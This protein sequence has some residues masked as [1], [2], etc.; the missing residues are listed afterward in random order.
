[1]FTK[2]Q[3]YICSILVYY[4]V[5]ILQ[6]SLYCTFNKYSQYYQQFEPFPQPENPCNTRKFMGIL[7]GSLVLEGHHAVW[8]VRVPCVFFLFTRLSKFNLEFNRRHILRVL[9]NNNLSVNSCMY[10]LESQAPPVLEL[11]VLEKS[12]RCN[13]AVAALRAVSRW[14]AVV[15]G[16][17][18]RSNVL[19]MF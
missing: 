17:I 6:H 14:I 19:Y 5:F 16:S 12:W 1:M 4:N 9:I 8:H 15:T 7:R 3:Q 2:I 11:T 10:K 18:I 13:L